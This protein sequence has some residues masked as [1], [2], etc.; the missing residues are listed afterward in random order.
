[1]TRGL[2]L[3]DLEQLSRAVEVLVSPFAHDTVDGWRS[4]VN[5]LLKPLLGADSAGFLLPGTD[6]LALYSEEHDPE[7]LDRYPDYPPPP[8]MDGTPVWEQWIRR[9]VLTLADGYGRD[10]DQYLNSVY[11]QEYAGANGA[12]DTLVAAISL[13]GMDARSMAALHFWHARPD[14]RR[15]GRREKALLRVLFP[16]FQAGVEAQA[17]WGR[18]RADLL[19]TLDRLNEAAMVFG[20]DGR[21][22]HATPAL[23]DLLAADPEEEVLRDAMLTALKGATS[24]PQAFDVRTARARYRIRPCVHGAGGAGGDT[25]ILIGLERRSPVPLPCAELREA[26]GLTR[27]EIRVATLIARGHANAEIA[28]ELSISPHTARRHTER[29]MLKLDVRSRAEVAGRIHG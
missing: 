22:L 19:D 16:A 2:S 23:S 14:G 26:F 4:A 21:L 27:A 9:G 13:G 17:R 11:Y 10:Y 8:L 1:M 15:F 29:V 28:R 18:H 6:G 5:R 20:V 7:E 24:R 12:H 25:L 3:D